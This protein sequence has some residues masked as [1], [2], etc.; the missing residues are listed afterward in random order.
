MQHQDK[1]Y[2]DQEVLNLILPCLASRF[3]LRF[4]CFQQHGEWIPFNLGAP[5]LE[6]FSRFHWL[7]LDAFVRK[8]DRNGTVL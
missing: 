8:C 3:I 1:T 4:L 6:T 7:E 2:E 5:I